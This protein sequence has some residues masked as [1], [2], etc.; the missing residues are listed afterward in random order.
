MKTAAILIVMLTLSSCEKQQED[1]W[2]KV[3]KGDY[4]EVGVESLVQDKSR[5]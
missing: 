5:E 3:Y 1:Y 2:L 4:D